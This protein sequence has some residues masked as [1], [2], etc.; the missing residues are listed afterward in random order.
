[1]TM[2]TAA[3]EVSRPL[4]STPLSASQKAPESTY[5]LLWGRVG[6]CKKAEL[7]LLKPA[8]G[9]FNACMCLYMSTAASD[10]R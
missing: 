9:A 3:S 7:E 5:W 10:A 6:S 8:F 4:H 2:R 1:M